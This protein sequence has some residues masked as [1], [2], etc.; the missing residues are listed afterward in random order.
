MVLGARHAAYT[1]IAFALSC[2]GTSE[3]PPDASTD[4]TLPDSTLPDSASDT[5][6]PDTSPTPDAAVADAGA[7][8]AADATSDASCSNTGVAVASCQFDAGFCFDY[9]GSGWNSS[10]IAG[11]NAEA[12]ARLVLDAGCPTTGQ[13]GTCGVGQPPYEFIER[14]YPPFG[15][16]Q[17]L[18]FCLIFDGGYCPN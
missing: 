2:G 15:P 14:C 7:D 13:I 3:S 5:F 16:N 17:C 11:C 10:N 9:T 4:A 6:V 12:G 1:A 8:A 18:G